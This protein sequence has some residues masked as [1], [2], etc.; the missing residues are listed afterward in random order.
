MFIIEF[1]LDSTDPIRELIMILSSISSSL[2]YSRLIPLCSLFGKLPLLLLWLLFWTMTL[3]ENLFLKDFK[4][5]GECIILDCL[6]LFENRA[7]R[8]FE[9]MELALLSELLSAPAL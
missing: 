1:F 7:T 5:A 2:I 3:P 9:N 4:E 6:M 8:G